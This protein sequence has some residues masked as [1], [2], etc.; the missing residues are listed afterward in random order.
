MVCPWKS[1]DA[2]FQDLSAG[3]SNNQHVTLA[4]GFAS[5]TVDQLQHRASEPE[6]QDT[7]SRYTER[8]C[9]SSKASQTVHVHPELLVSS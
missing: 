3:F 9:D 6:G 7:L 1:K 2:C 8:S 4:L 5:P